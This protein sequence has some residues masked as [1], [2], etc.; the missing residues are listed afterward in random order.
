MTLSACRRIRLYVRAVRH[1]LAHRRLILLLCAAALLF[2]LV[3][4]TGYM[5]AVDGGR[6]TMTICSG[7]VPPPPPPMDMPGMSGMHGADHDTAKDHGKAEQPCAF[8]GLSAAALGAIDPVQLA[9]LIAYVLA[10]GLFVGVLP[11]PA[12]PAY[13]RPPL[14]GPPTP[15]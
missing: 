9:A 14:R 15:L 6:L 1:L 10:A 13:L 11:A 4:P 2:K 5:I 3:V 12:R 7:T 8:A